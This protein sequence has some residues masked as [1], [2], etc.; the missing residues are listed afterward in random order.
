MSTTYANAKS[1]LGENCIGPEEL[2]VQGSSFR[3]G[4]ECPPVPY[5][6][7]QLEQ[8][9]VSSVLVFTPAHDADGSPVTL[10]SLRTLFGIDPAVSEP[11]FY[12]Q[13]WYLKEPFAAE[14][15]LDGGWHLIRREALEEVRAMLPEEIENALPA[16]EVF[17][18]A[19]TCAFAFFAYWF[20]T[21]GNMLWRHDFIWCS[22]R[23]HNGDRIYVGRYEDPMQM[24]KNGFNIHRHLRLKPIH[25]AAPETVPVDHLG[26][27]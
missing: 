3:F 18:T 15:T 26:K 27:M 21:G 11:C 9:A 13:D 24:N 12:N 4:S 2:A 5:S 23:D 25:T 10:N 22:D 1:I 20:A 14:A 8:H 17:P 6:V 7:E 16:T 19:V